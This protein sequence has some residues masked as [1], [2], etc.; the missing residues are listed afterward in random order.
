[1]IADVERVR[2]NTNEKARVIFSS[3]GA[4]V[5][6]YHN[7]PKFAALIDAADLI[8][9]DGMSLVFA[10]KLFC[11]Q[12]LFE[13]V[14]TTDFIHDACRVA[15]KENIRFYFLGGK[16]GIA[17]KA[18]ENLRRLY[19]GLQIVGT[20]HGYFTPS[21]TD[22][23]CSEIASSGAD[24]LW[25]GLGSPKQEELA[26]MFRDTLK[27]VAWVRTCGGLF[28]H[29]AGAVH[30]APLWVQNIGMEWFFRALQE[31]LRLGRRYIQ[32][33]PAAILHLLTKTRDS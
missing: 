24:I 22:S 32:T 23:I 1:M 27:G 2:A 31:P 18:A 12:P 20:H 10:S 30:R 25:L 9:A 16:D 17:V 15:I 6:H 8:D 14:A 19:P 13:R 21:Q 7:D 29:C 11:R 4:V 28:D 5:A 26:L 33:N 3:N